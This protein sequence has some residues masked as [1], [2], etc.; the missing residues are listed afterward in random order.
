MGY[1]TVNVHVQRIVKIGRGVGVCIYILQVTVEHS[2]IYIYMRDFN[3]YREQ[4]DRISKLGEINCA[5]DDI[6]LKFLH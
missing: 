1:S 5:R 6:T 2:N 4:Q 3:I